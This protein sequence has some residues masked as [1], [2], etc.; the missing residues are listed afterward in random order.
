MVIAV[1]EA[2]DLGQRRQGAFDRGIAKVGP[3]SCGFENKV[4]ILVDVDNDSLPHLYCLIFVVSRPGTVGVK[5]VE[6][7]LEC[8]TVG[9]GVADEVEFPKVAG[10]VGC[11]GD[12]VS[13]LAVGLA[14][15]EQSR[16]YSYG[17]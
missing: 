5:G 11:E 12:A 2:E 6:R 3:F 4:D 15:E 9:I 16:V 17:F 7:Y 14:V 1:A 13:F 10:A 8:D